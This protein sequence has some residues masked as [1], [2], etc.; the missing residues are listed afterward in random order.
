[1]KYI[2]KSIHREINIITHLAS[3]VNSDQLD[4]RPLKNQRSIK[5]L[6]IYLSICGYFGLQSIIHET[7]DSEFQK[8]Q[9]NEFSLDSYG[10][11]QTR[12]KQKIDNWFSRK[13]LP[14]LGKL[15]W[16][17]EVDLDIAV[18]EVPLKWLVAYRMN[19]F[20]WAKESGANHL[21]RTDCWRKW[22]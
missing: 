17:E 6:L 18:V 9:E 22:S 3:C 16:G 10:L 21:D 5:E 1:M 4:Y 8:N 20:L 2:Q 14:N 12:Q 19:L 11:L 13:D 7:R 15:Y